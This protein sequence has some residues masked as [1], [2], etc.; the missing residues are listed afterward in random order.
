[1]LQF[2]PE[3]QNECAFLGIEGAGSDPDAVPIDQCPGIGCTSRVI[4]KS[5]RTGS[6]SS[7]CNVWGRDGT[8]CQHISKLSQGEINCDFSEVRS[9]TCPSLATKRGEDEEDNLTPGQEFL[10]RLWK[11]R[12]TRKLSSGYGVALS[13]LAHLVPKDR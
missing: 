8:G 2:S 13:V 12:S 1:M 3:K 5:S 4:T 7:S 10:Y 9:S 11:P 6:V